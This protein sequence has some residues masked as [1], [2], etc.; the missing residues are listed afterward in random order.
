MCREE[1][2][3]SLTSPQPLQIS[4]SYDTN[5]ISGLEPEP[6]ALRKIGFIVFYWL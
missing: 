2:A 6:P 5:S 4:P 1:T 3:H